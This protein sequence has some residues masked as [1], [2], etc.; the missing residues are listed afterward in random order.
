ME[1][2][3]HVIGADADAAITLPRGK[4][5]R[6]RNRKPRAGVCSLEPAGSPSTLS[7]CRGLIDHDA[8]LRIAAAPHPRSDPSEMAATSASR[9]S[10]DRMD[11]GTGRGRYRPGAA[12]GRATAFGF[13]LAARVS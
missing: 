7:I 10:P 11:H 13:R 6:R 3:T 8:V 2:S 5:D 12:V 4:P 9:L 1:G